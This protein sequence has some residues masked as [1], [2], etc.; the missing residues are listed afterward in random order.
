MQVLTVKASGKMAFETLFM[1]SHQSP[2]ISAQFV[3]IESID[4][5]RIKLTPGHYVWSLP[6]G[7]TVG[8]GHE[9]LEAASKTVDTDIQ[10]WKGLNVFTKDRAEQNSPKRLTI[11]RTTLFGGLTADQV[12]ILRSKY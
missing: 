10:Q 11:R 1:F 4:G 5:Q 3:S 9:P 6:K 8:H 2:D 7:R 12:I